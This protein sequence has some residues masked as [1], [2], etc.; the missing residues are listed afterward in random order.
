MQQHERTYD[1]IVEDIARAGNI[2]DP[3]DRVITYLNTIPDIYSSLIQS[4]EPVLAT[5][6]SQTIKAKVR[7]EG[8]GRR[9]QQGVSR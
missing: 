3:E 5:L 7:E 1:A 9:S 2:L 4:T 8:H 6:T